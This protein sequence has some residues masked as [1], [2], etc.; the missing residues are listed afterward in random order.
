MVKSVVRRKQLVRVTYLYILR[1]I[2][3]LK[4]HSRTYFLLVLLYKQILLYDYDIR[5]KR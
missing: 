1:I 4:E 2:S 3:R 5:Y